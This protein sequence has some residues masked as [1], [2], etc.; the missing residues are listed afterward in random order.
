[1][2]IFY[3]YSYTFGRININLGKII[4]LAVTAKLIFAYWW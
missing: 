3:T 2:L 1:M 4:E